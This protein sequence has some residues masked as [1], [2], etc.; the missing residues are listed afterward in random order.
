MRIMIIT[1]QAKSYFIRIGDGHKHAV[2]RPMDERVDRVL[3]RMIENANHNGDC[4]IPRINGDGYYRPI[5]TDPVDALE[6]KTYI[7]KER[8][9]INNMREKEACMLVSYESRRAD[10]EIYDTRETG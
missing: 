1:E 8:S 5:P 4:I 3:R 7:M 9:K 2:K 10:D 6:F